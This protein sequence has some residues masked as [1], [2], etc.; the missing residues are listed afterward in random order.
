[1]KTLILMLAL[2]FGLN[3]RALSQARLVTAPVPSAAAPSAVAPAARTEE[4]CIVE[5]GGQLFSRKVTIAVDYGQEQKALGT[6]RV[7]DAEGRL[8]T[9]A[10]VVDALNYQNAQGWEL[11][12]VYTPVSGKTSSTYYLMKRRIAK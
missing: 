12:Q 8:Q 1:M 7:R 2:L 5:V 10:S 9:F 11:F 4:Y 6:S 3:S